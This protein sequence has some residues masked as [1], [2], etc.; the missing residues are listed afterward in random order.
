MAGNT[1]NTAG[2]NIKRILAWYRSP[3]TLVGSKQHPGGLSEQRFCG[4]GQ[5]S[6]AALMSVIDA[7][8]PT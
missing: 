2:R 7:L 3:N 8:C 4:S 6:F 1:C 5:T